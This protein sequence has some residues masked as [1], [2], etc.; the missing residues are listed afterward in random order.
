MDAR[1]HA[2]GYSGEIANRSTKKVRIRGDNEGSD[3]EMLPAPAD[4]P[5]RSWKDR[6]LGSGI[7]D[8]AKSVRAANMFDK[9]EF[10]LADFDII[11]SIIDGMPSIEF[12]DRVNNLL[13]KEI[14]QTVVIKLLGR[15]I[16]YT[17]LYN[18]VCSLWKSSH[19]F[20]LID[21]ENGYFLAKFQNTV[22][23][24]R[25]LCDGPWIVYGQYLTVQLWTI[26]FNT[27]QAYPTT[28][29]A[30]IRLPGFRDICI[31]SRFCGN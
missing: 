30:W 24:E 31:K 17:D 25:V 27:N 14:A 22:D 6:L 26:D 2:I 5:P 7:G 19:E 21:V 29:M 10:V 9:D 1:E 3:E 18:K 12:S 15:N 11:R 4:P 13:I 8:G 16:G 23:Y 20:R 28:V